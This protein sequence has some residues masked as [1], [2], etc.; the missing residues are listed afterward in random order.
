MKRCPYCGREYPDEVEHC[1]IDHRLLRGGA[2]PPPLPSASAQI[3]ARP[4][5]PLLSAAAAKPKL[6]DRQQRIIELLLV[7]IIAFG[8]GILISGYFLAGHSI[9]NF[10]VSLS[11][12]TWGWLAKILHESA[13]LGLVWYF[14]AR[15]GKSFA[16]LGLKWRWSDVG[17]SI[18]L[19]VGAGIAFVGVYEVLYHSGLT[20][21]TYD[22]T[23]LR[24][25]RILFGGGVSLLTILFQ[26]LNPFFE[27]LI[28][29]AYVMTEIKRLTGSTA[30]AVI[31]ST[32]LQTSYHFYQ[33]TPAALAH[34]ASFL[35]FSLYY[36]RTNRISPIILAHCYTDV[37]GT[38]SYMF[39]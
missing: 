6:T 10:S 14:L 18:L 13:A 23:F 38:L 20:R 34:G 12:S 21:V 8:G 15:R 32:V 30:Q 36:A 24:V 7:C 28:V 3:A 25:G 29:R 19:N 22:A 11:S 5:P 4:V 33:G 26:F 31:V 39:R 9:N 2:V 37:S 35:I 1:P 17:W 27:E 16:D